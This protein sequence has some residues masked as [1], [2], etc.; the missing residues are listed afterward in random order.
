VVP[1]TQTTDQTCNRQPQSQTAA[2]EEA[3]GRPPVPRPSS[4]LLKG[5][6]AATCQL[7]Q[8][9]PQ[10]TH[11]D[12]RTTACSCLHPGRQRGQ[13]RP[14]PCTHAPPP[15]TGKLAQQACRS[16]P[17]A[18][19][20]QQRLP[21]TA[22]QA[23]AT[24]ILGR[25]QCWVLKRGRTSADHC[26]SVAPMTRRVGTTA[27]QQRLPKTAGQAA[28][29]FILGRPQCWVLKRGRTSADHCYSVA[30]MTRRVGTTARQQRFP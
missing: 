13:G 21:K 23:A 14:T 24:F 27:R 18:A 4:P 30:P 7:T 9:R 11:R 5:T 22:G 29:T 19:A 8:R 25:P 20:R 2:T 17:K 3:H 16:R 28:A 15:S 12:H 10:P 6:A 26:Y 1:L